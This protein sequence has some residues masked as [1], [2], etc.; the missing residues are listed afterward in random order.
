M[1]LAAIGVMFAGLYGGM[2]S[3]GA[4]FTWNRL[5]FDLALLIQ[6]PLIHSFFLTP[7]GRRILTLGGRSKVAGDLA[8][9]TFVFFTSIQ[10]LAVFLF[11]KPTGPI[12]WNAPQGMQIFTAAVF[13]C[14]WLML[15]KSMWDSD[16]TLQT[17]LKGWFAVF[18]GA[19]PKYLKFSRSGMY[20]FCRQPIYLSFLMILITGPHWTLDRLMI[21]AVWGSYCVLGA[22]A[23]ERR[24]ARI[25]GADFL[26]Y[27]TEV[28]FFFPFP[29]LKPAAEAP[30]RTAE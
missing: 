6:F 1:F 2:L 12:V 18:R 24:F 9:T 17:G 20:R 13:V 15:G 5:G 10:L 7:A 11:W 28:P 21:A 14:S 4:Y 30:G 26:K 23:K 3:S 25:F 27:Q 29:R 16:L 19:K 8:T 22:I